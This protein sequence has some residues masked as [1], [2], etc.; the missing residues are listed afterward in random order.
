MEDPAVPD[1][2]LPFDQLCELLNCSFPAIRQARRDAV[3][4]TDRIRASLADVRMSPDVALIAFGSLARREWTSG[5]DVDWT[6]L[7]DGPSDPEHFTLTRE[8]E[9]RLCDAEFPGVGS[10]G[11]F[12]SMASSFELIHFIGGSEDSN[13]KMTRRVLLLLE[14]VC[15]SDTVVHERVLRGILKRYIQTDPAVATENTPQFKV[16]LFLLNDVV[17]LWRTIAVDY[18]TKKWQQG[19]A[20]WALRNIKLRMSRKLLFVKGLLMCFSCKLQAPQAAQENDTLVL[21][22]LVSHCLDYTGK[23]AIDALAEILL[24][25]NDHQLAVKLLKAYDEFLSSISDPEKRKHLNNLDFSAAATDPLFQDV[26]Q[27]S[28]DFRDGLGE[29]FFDHPLLRPLTREFGLF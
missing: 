18:A 14:S 1:S 9:Q 2:A 28:Y 6:L 15:F 22:S 8:I 20:K 10:S 3:Q 11:T 25:T 21:D 19:G 5:S 16:P 29:L 17:R 12:G 7:V 23:T 26:R 24:S 13:Q 27:I 4:T